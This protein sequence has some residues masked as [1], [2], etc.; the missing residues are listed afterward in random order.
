MEYGIIESK[1]QLIKFQREIKQIVEQAIKADKKYTNK[2]MVN[3]MGSKFEK[4]ELMNMDF[5]LDIINK[6][7][8]RQLKSFR[9]SDTGSMFQ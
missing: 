4:D 6:E 7:M 3:L 2:E 5:T 8:N 1:K 9:H